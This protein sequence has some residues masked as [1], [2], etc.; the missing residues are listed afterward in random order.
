ALAS[1]PLEGE[2]LMGHMTASGVFVLGLPA[3]AWLG[4]RHL[5][6][7]SPNHRIRRLGYWSVL[8]TGWLTVASVFAC[9]LPV[10]GTDSMHRLISIHGYAGF[11]ML[12]AMALLCGGLIFF[13]NQSTRSDKPG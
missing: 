1:Q 12:P 11:A 2:L 6:S 8:T 3:L 10:F 9:M 4:L 5:A 7:D 13:R